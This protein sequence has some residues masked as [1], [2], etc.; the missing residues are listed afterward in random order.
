MALTAVNLAY[1]QDLMA[2]ARLAIENQRL[3]QYIGEVKS[4]WMRGESAGA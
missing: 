3:P 2:G 1:Y 4:G